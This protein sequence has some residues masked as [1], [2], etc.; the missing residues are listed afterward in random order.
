LAAEVVKAMATHGFFYA[1]NHGYTQDQTT[2]V[3]ST[4]TLMFDNVSAEEKQVYTGKSAAV[5]E[6]YKPW[7]TW[8]VQDGVWDQIE[9]YN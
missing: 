2:R 9:H 7:Q 8:C 5:Y 6:G 4:A 1:V 3:S